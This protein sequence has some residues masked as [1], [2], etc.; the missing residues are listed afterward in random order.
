ML[1]IV[2]GCVG[3]RAPRI[4]V[5]IDL[6]RFA[7]YF[8]PLYYRITRTTPRFTPYSIET[9]QSNSAISN[10]KARKEL[11]F[12]PLRLSESLTDTVAWWLQRRKLAYAKVGV[13]RDQ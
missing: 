8:T 2:Q 7:A 10:A 12:S 3:I 5:P 4:K 9:V 6:A 13:L 1:Q 11:G